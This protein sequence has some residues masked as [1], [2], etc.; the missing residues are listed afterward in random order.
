MKHKHYDLIV[1]WAEGKDIQYRTIGQENWHVDSCPWWDD[2]S[3][4]FRIKPKDIVAYAEIHAGGLI[5]IYFYSGVFDRANCKAT[6]DGETRKL[7]SLE[8]IK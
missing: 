4:E 6:F 8:M 1:A 3:M 7:K 5:P 2:H